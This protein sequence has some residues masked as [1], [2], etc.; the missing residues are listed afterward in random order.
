MDLK[1]IFTSVSA[2]LL[3]AFFFKGQNAVWGGATAGAIVGLIVG[4]ISVG[5]GNGLMWGFSIGT[6]SGAALEI[7]GMLGDRLKR[8]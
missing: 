1:L 7:P 4:L 2:V 8:T 5:V 3:V 6:I